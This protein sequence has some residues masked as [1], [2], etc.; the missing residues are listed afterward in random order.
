MQE[1]AFANAHVVRDFDKSQTP[2]NSRK[3][4]L[5]VTIQDR[6]EKAGWKV[7]D[8]VRLHGDVE[9]LPEET[10]K[11]WEEFGSLE[12]MLLNRLEHGLKEF[13]HPHL[14]HYGAALW[15]V[16]SSRTIT[17]SL[18]QLW[19]SPTRFP[20]LRPARKYQ[21]ELMTVDKSGEETPSPWRTQDIESLTV[22]IKS[23]IPV[24]SLGPG[25]SGEMPT[26]G[27]PEIRQ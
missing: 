21:I 25:E 9:D 1:F 14:Q 26:T 8:L 18:N 27:L 23:W 20:E 4:F 11:R 6:T 19:R 5:R 22:A 17:V 15:D 24:P 3:V 16:Y 2:W 7:S 13:L 12:S 10:F